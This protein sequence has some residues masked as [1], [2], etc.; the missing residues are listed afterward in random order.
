MA[1]SQ[2]ELEMPFVTVRSKDGPHDDES[3]VAGFEMGRL[4]ETLRSWNSASGIGY[5]AVIL[6]DNVPQADLISMHYGFTMYRRESEV[7][8]WTHVLFSSSVPK[9]VEGFLA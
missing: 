6:T 9:E 4:Y 5:E 7:V 3:Y 2:Y 8:G 1:E